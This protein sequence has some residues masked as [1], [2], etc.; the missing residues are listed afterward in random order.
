[1]QDEQVL[2]G[3]NI[4][5]VVRV[6]STIRRIAGPWSTMVH[7]HLNHLR[8]REFELGPRPYGFDDQG[9]EILDYIPGETLVAHPWP[10]WVYSDAVLIEA[11]TALLTYQHCVK[12]FRPATV[13]SRLGTSQMQP[14]F[15]VCHNDFAPYNC[16]FHEG[17]LVGIYDRDCVWAE[18]PEWDLAFA[19]WHWI[20]LY[21]PSD[22]F[23]WRTTEDC[24]RRLE[25]LVTTYGLTVR[26]GFIDMIL[27]RINTIRRGILRRA[28]KGEAAFVKMQDVGHALAMQNDL[29]F[30]R[31][32]A[33]ELSRALS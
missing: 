25:L 8:S 16:A 9:R 27:E 3:G 2:G 24:I 14:E 32:H 1:M 15:V 10:Q 11:V 30:V 20:P 7:D 12:D 19:A 28:N 21:A 23:E 29:D 33:H 17:H 31:E 18:R 26:I 6:G 4:A 22:E 5:S 13:Q